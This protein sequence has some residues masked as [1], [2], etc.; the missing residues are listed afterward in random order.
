[1]NQLDAM[2]PLMTACFSD[3]PDLTPYDAVPNAV[4]LDQLNPPVEALAP[5]DRRWAEASL[6]QDFEGFDRADEDTLNRILWH[7]AR[8][9]D[10]PYPAEFAGAHGKGLKGRKLV[11][12]AVLDDD[13]E[14]EEGED[15]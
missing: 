7:F 6:A 12:I 4:P 3:E 8:G 1:M 13:D 14:N 2:S 9:S 15:D 11:H 5:A 10:A